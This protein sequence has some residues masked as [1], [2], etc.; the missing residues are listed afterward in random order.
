MLSLS[1][2]RPKADQTHNA[3]CLSRALA[4]GGKDENGGQKH[5]CRSKQHNGHIDHDFD[6]D[7][8]HR[9]ADAGAD[10]G[11]DA[12]ADDADDAADDDDTDDADDADADGVD[13][14]EIRKPLSA[15]P[16]QGAS[17]QSSDKQTALYYATLDAHICICI[18]MDICICICVC[19]C[20]QVYNIAYW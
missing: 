3:T 10:V 14:D 19:I 6:D 15:Q 1:Q 11:V 5:S 8:Y 18:Q 20:I 2:L 12:D 4:L 16:T 13:D 7:E 17:S 9:D